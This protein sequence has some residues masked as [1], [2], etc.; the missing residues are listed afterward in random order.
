MKTINS[1]F[2]IFPWMHISTTPSGTLRVCCHSDNSKNKILKS[3]GSPYKIYDQESLKEAWHSPVYK[4]IRREMLKGVRP[5]M[6]APCF[7]EESACSKSARMRAN[8]KYMFDWEASET[9]PFNIKYIDLRLGNK[10]NLRCRM[11]SPYASS[12][13]F[14]E[15]EELSKQNVS[16]FILPVPLGAEKKEFKK[17]TWPEKMDFS[18]LLSVMKYVEEIY[19]TGGEPLLIQEQYHLL[20]QIISKGFASNI[21]LK[22]NTNM[23]KYDSQILQLWKHFKEVRLFISIDGFGKLNDYIR[24]PSQWKKIEANLK[25]IASINE[26]LSNITFRID[27]TVQMYNVTAMTDLLLWIKQQNFNSYF[28]I[29]DYPKFLNIRVLPDKLKQKAKENLLLFSKSF[30][31]KKIIDYMEKESWTAYLGDFFRYTDFFD[32][33]RSQNL[34]DVLPELSSYRER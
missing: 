20:D 7:R 2:C 33:S 31:V 25:E 27:C 24:Y 15:W 21:I 11:C 5:E 1:A 9:P 10:C 19:L 34:N 14:R 26:T 28:N 13:L 32:K 29:L 4:K 22:Y 3:D 12:S 6:C 8:Q 16:R 18:E 23:T 17:L 30:P